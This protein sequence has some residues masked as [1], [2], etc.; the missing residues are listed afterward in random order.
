MIEKRITENWDKV[1]SNLGY[2]AIDL[3]GRRTIFDFA[4]NIENKQFGFDVKT[5][6]QQDILSVVCV[7]LEIS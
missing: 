1:C 3:P 5:L 4:C 7:Q 6:I 2:Q